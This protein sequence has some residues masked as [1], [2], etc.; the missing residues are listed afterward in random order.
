MRERISRILS[1]T[2]DPMIV[3]LGAHCGDDT[4]W[5]HSLCSGRP[6]YLVVEADRR[7]IA[8]LEDRVQP[9]RIPVICVAIAAYT[10]FAT[11][12]LSDNDP[13]T[14]PA[15]SSIRRP[16]LH[17]EHWPWCR[18]DRDVEV[19]CVTLDDLLADW[20]KGDRKIDLLWADIQGAERDM[21]EGGR[22]TLARTRWLY[23]E[24]YECEM[25]EGQAVR[26]EL[27]AM[28]PDF[29]LVMQDTENVL[30]EHR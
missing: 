20:L 26:S 7:H 27:L 21:V 17:L 24:A 9:M 19:P 4:I 6:W 2:P 29:Q 14:I 28:L 25:Y 10:G 15:S 22:Q 5:L 8:A 12:H 23:M 18:F 1:A 30:L 11:L 13:G 3:E 16:K